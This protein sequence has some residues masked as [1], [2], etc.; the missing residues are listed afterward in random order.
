MILASQYLLWLERE[1]RPIKYDIFS[2]AALPGEHE[3][4]ASSEKLILPSM[5]GSKELR[6]LIAKKYCV[7]LENVFVTTGVTLLNKIIV[8]TFASQRIAVEV[9][10]YEPLYNVVL[11]T[12][13]WIVPLERKMEKSYELPIPKVPVSMLVITNPNNPTGVSLPR[14]N[15]EDIIGYAEKYHTIILSDEVYNDSSF[16]KSTPM[17]ALSRN[18]ITVSHLNKSY[19][20]GVLKLGWAIG[21]K[22]LIER[23][24]EANTLYHADVFCI[25]DQMAQRV[26]HEENKWKETSM[27]RLRRNHAIVSEWIASR[28][29]VQWVPSNGT[30]IC[31]VKVPVNDTRKFVDYLIDNYQTR[32]VPGYYF[33]AEGFL[34]IGYGC[35][36]E[37]LI[38]GLARLG[39][40]LEDEVE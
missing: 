10:V 19:G 25:V 32:V 40:A 16:E 22:N 5:N 1:N 9:P 15:I 21:D 18:A 11:S 12:G 28:K 3:V 36:E 7:A 14:Q 38:E 39:K 13:S 37:V 35:R 23:I 26:L 24:A 8:E 17:H 27:S 30:P 33:G 20:L 31:F 2:S 6:E 34:R 29:D 4:V